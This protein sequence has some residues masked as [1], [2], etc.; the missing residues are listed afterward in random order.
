MD[1]VIVEDI[2]ERDPV[3]PGDIDVDLAAMPAED[4]VRYLMSHG[5]PEM[6]ARFLVSM[7][8]GEIGGTRSVRMPDAR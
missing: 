2:D 4:A 5:T 6:D 7:A 8:K 3:R 1:R